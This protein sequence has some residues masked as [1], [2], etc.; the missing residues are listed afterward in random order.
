[1]VFLLCGCA[2]VSGRIDSRVDVLARLDRSQQA[3]L[4]SS[5]NDAFKAAINVLR[6]LNISI[7][8]KDYDK[9]MIIGTRLPEEICSNYGIYFD[10]IA[11]NETKITVKAEG[12]YYNDSFVL[13]KIEEEITL[14]QKLK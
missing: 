12:L 7:L 1:M 5:Y 4:S 14:Q 6:D 10:T 8:K 13:Q 9:R 2:S 3:T 11:A